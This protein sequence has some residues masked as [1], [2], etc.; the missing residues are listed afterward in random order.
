MTLVVPD[1]PPE[2]LGLHPKKPSIGSLGSTPAMN[3][4]IYSIDSE[5][6]LS[7][8]EVNPSEMR[9]SR[10]QENEEA[11]K[12]SEL[13]RSPSRT[14]FKTIANVARLGSGLKMEKKLQPRKDLQI[15]SIDTE[16]DS[17]VEDVAPDSG[18]TEQDRNITPVLD[19]LKGAGK[20]RKSIRDKIGKTTTA[21][22]NTAKKLYEGQQSTFKRTG[23]RQNS[24]G[25]QTEQASSSIINIPG[26]AETPEPD[27]ESLYDPQGG[28]KSLFVYLISDSSNAGFRKNCIGRVVLPE[29]ERNMTLSQLRNT[30]LKSEEDS[31]KSI[32]RKNK[33]FKFVTETY[34]FVAQNEQAANVEDIYANQGIF[35][36]L[37]GS[38]G[39][40][41][42]LRIPSRNETGASPVSGSNSRQFRRPGSGRKGLPHRNKPGHHRQ[43][44]QLDSSGDLL[45]QSSSRRS[46]SRYPLSRAKHSHDT[47][48]TLDDPQTDSKHYSAFHVRGNV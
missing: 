46:P 37:E 22:F 5:R 3:R 7:D 11:K 20:R 45:E 36:K 9:S 43:V 35:V 47:L 25:T 29:G 16:T 32:L 38:Q 14:S 28:D 6:G 34:R 24:A 31:I 41:I 17:E 30:L 39:V 2:Q 12:T 8:T 42:E 48:D 18:F 27:L 40:P 44:A 33:S 10:A 21:V 15:D 13:E 23:G 4:G 19:A 1:T 26:L